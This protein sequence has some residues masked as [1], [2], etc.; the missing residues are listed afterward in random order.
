MFS[1][2]EFSVFSNFTEK[3][4]EERASGYARAAIRHVQPKET[5]KTPN[6]YNFYLDNVIYLSL[7]WA[8]YIS[9]QVFSTYMGPS[10][11]VS[12]FKV[13]F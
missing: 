2:L 10:L 3:P 11:C 12:F 6:A 13:F 7:R 8:N 4:N 9:I 1:L 5:E